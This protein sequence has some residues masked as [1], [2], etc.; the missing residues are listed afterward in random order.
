MAMHLRETGGPGWRVC[1][2]NLYR[3]RG[4]ASG[5]KSLYVCGKSLVLND[6]L[7]KILRG[8]NT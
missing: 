6:M 3:S 4:E 8:V 5:K 1:S 7:I 2:E